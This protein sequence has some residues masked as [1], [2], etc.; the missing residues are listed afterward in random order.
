MP[1]AANPTVPRLPLTQAPAAS[2]LLQPLPALGSYGTG[3]SLRKEGRREGLMR[4]KRA[5]RREG[6]VLT[7]WTGGD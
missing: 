7:H 5:L 6:R 4:A 2:L 1:S 3:Q